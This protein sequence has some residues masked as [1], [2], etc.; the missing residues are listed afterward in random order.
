VRSDVATINSGSNQDDLLKIVRLDSVFAT[1]THIK[2]TDVLYISVALV[3]WTED[4]VTS[5]SQV[6][7]FLSDKSSPGANSSQVNAACIIHCLY[8]ATLH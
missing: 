7:G 2:I 1:K 8:C 4:F 6:H 5:H 3:E